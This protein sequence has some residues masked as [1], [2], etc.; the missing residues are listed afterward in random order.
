MRCFGTLPS[1]LLTSVFARQLICT[2]KA[3]WFPQVAGLMIIG[4]EVWWLPVV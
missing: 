3:R 2:R 1:M 4:F